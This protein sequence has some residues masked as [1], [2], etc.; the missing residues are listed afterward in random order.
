MRLDVWRDKWGIK[1]FKINLSSKFYHFFLMQDRNSP[2][3]YLM[4]RIRLDSWKLG[5]CSAILS[6]RVLI[7]SGVWLKIN[8]PHPY[9]KQ[10]HFSFILLH[11][12]VLL[13][14]FFGSELSKQDL[15]LK[16]V[17]NCTCCKNHF[18]KYIDGIHASWEVGRILEFDW[19]W[20]FFFFF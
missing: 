6:R 1:K 19:Y 13:Q 11:T 12:I 7:H 9:T 4:E 5:N 20:I 17:F 8:V 2:R 15:Q 3:P 10:I 14:P 16:N 18:W